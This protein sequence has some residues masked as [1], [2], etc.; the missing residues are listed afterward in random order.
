[1]GL[2]FSSREVHPNS[3]YLCSKISVINLL[4]GPWSHEYGTGSAIGASA[5]QKGI[6]VALS[7]CKLKIICGGLARAHQTFLRAH[8]LKQWLCEERPHGHSLESACS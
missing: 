3:Q 7:R 5:M 2:R 1:M 8:R 6:I 4:D